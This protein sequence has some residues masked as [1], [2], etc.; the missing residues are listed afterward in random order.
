[1]LDNFLKN[2]ELKKE[3]DKEGWESPQEL[4][5]HLTEIKK[6]IEFLFKEPD[7]FEILEDDYRNRPFQKIA[8]TTK[9]IWDF[10]KVPAV[11]EAKEK[12]KEAQEKAKI[13]FNQ[14]GMNEADYEGAK[15]RH[16]GF[17]QLKND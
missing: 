16:I 17:F 5:I 12:L 14:K 11:Q 15:E 6:Q 8:Y 13:L 10:S 2:L 3:R 9:K 4:W 1:M 7:F